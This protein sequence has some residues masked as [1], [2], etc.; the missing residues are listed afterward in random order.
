MMIPKIIHYCWFGGNK[1]PRLALK[2]IESWKKHLPEYELKLW[3]ESNFDINCNT[4][5]KQAYIHKKYAFVSDYVRLYALYNYGGIY[6]DTDVEVL[7]P[8]DG[9][10][11]HKAFSGF[12]NEVNI[13]TG[14]MGAKKKNAWIKTLFDNYNNRHFIDKNGRMDITTNVS[15]ATKLSKQC[16]LIQ[17]NMR[18]VLKTGEVNIYPDYYFC[19][20]NA[21]TG[22]NHINSKSHVIHHYLGSWQ[23]PCKRLRNKIII[24]VGKVFGLRIIRKLRRIITY[25]NN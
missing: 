10:L 15:I 22:V 5:V 18:Q 17:N 9:F 19:P 2:C 14:I 24:I 21:I 3:N 23:S 7:K 1:M 6:M 20:Y 12:E 16:G 13:S 25:L 4:Y 8:L 11:H